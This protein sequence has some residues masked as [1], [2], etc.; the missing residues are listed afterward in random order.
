M[1]RGPTETE[2]FRANNMSGS[3]DEMRYL[4]GVLMRQFGTLQEIA[5]AIGF[6]LSDD[7]GLIAGQTLHVDGGVWIGKASF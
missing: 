5:A 7:A 1:A 6:L 3:A 4:S 2:L